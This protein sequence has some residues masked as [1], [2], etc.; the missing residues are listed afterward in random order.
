M[1]RSHGTSRRDFLATSAIAAT[2][3]FLGIGRNISYS[4]DKKKEATSGSQPIIERVLGRTGIRV[5]IVGMGV[6]NAD[7]PALVRRAFELGVRH[8]DTAA[9]YQRGRNEEMVG[10]V[11]EELKSRDAVT[12]ATK[13]FLPENQRNR[14]AEKIKEYYM[15]VIDQSLERL[16]MD[17]VDILYLHN[18]FDL[19]WLNNPAVIEALQEIQAKKKTRYI[20]F[21]TH[22]NM[23]EI[24]T[25]AIRSGVY[26]VVLTTFNYSLHDF[27]MFLETLTKAAEKGMGLVAMK[28]QCQQPWYKEN[29]PK[30][31]QKFYEGEIVNSALL[32]WVLRHEYIAC[33]VPGYTAF[34]QLEED[35]PVAHSLEYTETEKKFLEDRNVTLGMNSVCRLCGECIPTCPRKADIPNILRTHMYAA[36]YG[37][38]HHARH[39]LD[40][41]PIERSINVC[42]SCTTC[43]AQCVRRVDIARRVDELKTMYMG[44]VGERA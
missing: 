10:K 42:V 9:T 12:I 20:G 6:M 38:F 3:G 36:S 27:G 39:T 32:K 26:D 43:T 35:I 37:N 13:I 4:N 2:A 44:R 17:Y 33:A 28:T 7:N 15:K 24:I 40:S 22:M 11:I 18:V 19:A 8:F 14:P 5:P 1:K 25:D 31:T 30:E 41:I 23:N 21:T 16:R 29:N 34:T